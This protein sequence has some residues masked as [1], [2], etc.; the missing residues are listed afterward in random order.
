M[1]VMAVLPE[2]DAM[3][4]AVSLIVSVVFSKKNGGKSMPPL[5]NYCYSL[6]FISH[7]LLALISKKA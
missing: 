2:V 7:S 3:R 1:T 6:G 5:L 4:T